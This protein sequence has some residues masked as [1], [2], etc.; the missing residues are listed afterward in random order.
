MATLG[1]LNL[2]KQGKPSLQERSQSPNLERLEL[3]SPHDETQI[4]SNKQTPILG[5]LRF[6]FLKQSSGFGFY[7]CRVSLP[8]IGISAVRAVSATDTGRVKQYE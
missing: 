6:V 2:G 3:R 4:Q 7:R 5:G 1:L 8:N